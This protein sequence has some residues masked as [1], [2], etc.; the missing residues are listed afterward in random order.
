VIFRWLLAGADSL[1]NAIL[2]RAHDIPLIGWILPV[3]F[4]AT[5][6]VIAV[7]IVFRFAPEAGGSGIPH[8]KAVLHRLRDLRWAPV[9]WVKLIGG[10]L[11]IGSGMAL[12]REGP[13]VQMGGAVGDGLARH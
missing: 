6:A 2:I 13:T 1:R 5:L 3:T 11:A 9:L 10:V 7:S 4:S 12:G 8:L